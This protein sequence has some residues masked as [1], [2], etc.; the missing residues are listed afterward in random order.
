MVSLGTSRYT[1]LLLSNHIFWYFCCGLMSKTSSDGIQNQSISSEKYHIRFLMYCHCCNLYKSLCVKSEYSKNLLNGIPF[2]ISIMKQ[3]ICYQRFLYS[4]TFP[5]NSLPYCCEKSPC[6]GGRETSL[7]CL[8]LCIHFV[9]L[10]HSLTVTA[11]PKKKK[12]KKRVNSSNIIR[13]LLA[14]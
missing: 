9:T 6:S 2:W 13:I 5:Y 1:E 8:C 3:N 10:G 4:Q 14:I 12:K 11:K 7:P